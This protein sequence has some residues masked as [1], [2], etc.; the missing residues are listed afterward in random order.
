MTP[1][2]HT[3]GTRAGP[4]GENT[5]LARPCDLSLREEEGRAGAR[6]WHF[7]GQAWWT[8]SMV[9]RWSFG[10]AGVSEASRP[11][12][13][14]C[15]MS[16]VFWSYLRGSSDPLSWDWAEKAPQAAPLLGTLGGCPFLPAGAR[17]G[18]A[19]CGF[20][21]PVGGALPGCLWQGSPNLG[22]SPHGLH[23]P[24]DAGS[25]APRRWGGCEGAG[26]PEPALQG[27][28]S[29]PPEAGQ[30]S[31][32]PAV[33]R[34]ARVCLGPVQTPVRVTQSQREARLRKQRRRSA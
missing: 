18:A 32:C 15:E 16:S 13:M 17:R 8:R 14:C 30:P 22:P 11:L 5:R 12:R 29:S 19:G 3:E 24:P 6:G 1:A 31:L 28:S 26:R 34:A 7:P 9:V 4:Q 21:G 33:H 25:P 27:S 20:P 10:V 23:R 2:V